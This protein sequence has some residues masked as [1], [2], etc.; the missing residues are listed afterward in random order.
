MVSTDF[1]RLHVR[2]R[3]LSVRVA[4]EYMAQDSKAR[5]THVYC[6]RITLHNQVE[7]RIYYHR[8]TLHNH[9]GE[10]LST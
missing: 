7:F 3:G 1:L 9:E 10:I 6:Y 5:G 2:G 8:V 4:S